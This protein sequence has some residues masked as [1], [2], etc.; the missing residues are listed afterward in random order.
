L[1]SLFILLNWLINSHLNKKERR[2][3]NF[4]DCF[5]FFLSLKAVTAIIVV[6]IRYHGAKVEETGEGVVEVVTVSG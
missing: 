4:Y 3:K 5:D 2:K 6:A 1:V